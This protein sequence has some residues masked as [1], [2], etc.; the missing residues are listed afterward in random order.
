MA[1]I[2]LNKSDSRT[3]FP[4]SASD[5]TITENTTNP[6]AYSST[7]TTSSIKINYQNRF[8]NEKIAEH[9]EKGS[10]SNISSG[11]DVNNSSTKFEYENVR[12]DN[13]ES[14]NQQQRI[15]SISNLSN[16]T[17]Y[18]ITSMSPT[19]TTRSGTITPI[20]YHYDRK[21]SA[22]NNNLSDRTRL[23]G[24]SGGGESSLSIK[25]HSP[26][27]L[28]TTNVLMNQN[29]DSTSVG[30]T[31]LVGLSG[32]STENQTQKFNGNSS[33]KFNFYICFFVA[34]SYQYKNFNL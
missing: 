31:T 13:E 17:A 27:H 3:K 11:N 32:K 28:K 33:Y 1:G 15:N 21:D 19:T 29:F 4:N 23:Y 30:A 20:K 2:L 12:N 24:N 6:N 5:K 22:S 25:I 9:S 14:L 10:L 16:A 34:Y 7:T 26:V 18:K 8:I